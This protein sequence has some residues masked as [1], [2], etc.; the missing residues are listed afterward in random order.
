MGGAGHVGLPLSIAFASKGQRVLVFDV[1]PSALEKISRGEMPFM[2]KGAEPVLRQVLDKELLSC[3]TDA[4]D[5]RGVPVIVIT[6]GTPVDEF[7]NPSLKAIRRCVDQLLP[8]LSDEQLMFCGL[9]YIPAL[10][11]QSPPTLFRRAAA[12]G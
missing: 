5:L 8:F 6:I 7:L 4:A 3:T 10:P 2:E 12:P 11:S 9:L 1:N